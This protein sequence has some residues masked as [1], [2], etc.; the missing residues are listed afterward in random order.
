MIYIAA[1]IATFLLFV[2]PVLLIYFFGVDFEGSEWQEDLD[3]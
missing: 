3:D 1:A 2:A